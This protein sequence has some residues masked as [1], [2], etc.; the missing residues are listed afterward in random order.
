[1]AGFVRPPTLSSADVQSR[2]VALRQLNPKGARTGR[3]AQAA[4]RNGAKHQRTCLTP[5]L[6][7]RQVAGGERQA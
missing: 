6:R 1:M 5:L 4:P 3:R 7:R 2:L